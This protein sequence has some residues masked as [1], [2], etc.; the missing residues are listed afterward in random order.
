MT[1]LKALTLIAFIL[2]SAGIA[3]ALQSRLESVAGQGRLP[4]DN[5]RG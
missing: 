5:N 3:A 1:S 4:P 2:L